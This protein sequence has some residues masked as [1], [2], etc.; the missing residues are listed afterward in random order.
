M[1]SLL[2]AFALAVCAAGT[3]PAAPA[4]AAFHLWAIKEIFSNA[5]GTV[6]FIEFFTTS[7]SETQMA[8]HSLRATSDGVAVTYLFDH[9]FTTSTANKHFIVATSGF[10]DLPGG[11]ASDFAPLP[12]N[13]F[14]PNA[15]SI[16]IDFH[17]GT[18][19]A[20]LAGSLLPKDGVNSLTDT[21]TQPFNGPDNFVAGVNS[22]TNFAGQAGSIDLGGG[23]PKPGDFDGDGAVGGDDLGAWQAGFGMEGDGVDHADGDAD[24]DNDVDGADFLLWQQDVGAA[25]AR[26]A[27]SSVPEPSSALLL[28]VALLAGMKQRR[29][30]H[31]PPA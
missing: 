25:P 20:T 2:R 28:S 31:A 26:A 17:F 1:P 5:D 15:A 27:A 6:Q 4:R 23:E 9:N 22:P 30:R 16:T 14:N 8:A 18:D 13:F 19:V 7:G 3:M 12:A 11:V 29:R 10:A 21:N 24:D